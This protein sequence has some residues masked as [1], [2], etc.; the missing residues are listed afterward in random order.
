MFENIE[1]FFFYSFIH[2]VSQSVNVLPE[3]VNSFTQ[4]IQ[5]LV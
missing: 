1:G 4:G 3:A 2:P 5:V